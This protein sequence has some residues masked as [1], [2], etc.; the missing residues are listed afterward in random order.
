MNTANKPA[1]NKL[2]QFTA[3]KLLKM[4]K[5]YMA[6][7]DFQK[8][9]PIYSEIWDRSPNDKE[10]LVVLS[11]ILTKLAYREQAILLLESA[12]K[13]FG[14]REDVLQIL[15]DMAMNME[16]FDTA[17]KIFRIYIDTYPL[18]IHAYNNLASTLNSQERFDE[19]ID[20][21]QSLLEVYP[22]NA[23]LWNTLGAAVGTRDG[24]IAGLVFLE[25]ASR[26]D[27]KNPNI[28]NNIARTYLFLGRTEDTMEVGN[29]VLKL[30][31]N[32]YDTK[33]LLSTC[34]LGL[35]QLDKGWKYY[36][37]RRDARRIAALVYTNNIPEWSG[38]SLADKSIL[39]MSE[40]GLGDEILFSAFIT[41]IYNEAAQVYIGC[42]KRLISLFKRTFPKAIV[43]EHMTA[44]Q[45]G[46]IMRS[47]PDVEIARNKG[48]LTV[49]YRISIGSIA[50]FY[51]KSHDDI[52]THEGGFLV[53]DPT[54]VKYW[55]AKLDKISDKPKVG[56][57]WRSGNMA[58]TRKLGYTELT[59]WDTI[60]KTDKVNF[61]NIQYG[62]CQEEIAAA[63]KKFGV[64]IHQME[65]IDLKKDIDDSCALFKC[66]DLTLSPANAPGWQS[67]AVGTPVWWLTGQPYWFFGEQKPKMISNSNYI[68]RPIDM[69]IEVYMKMVG[70]AFNKFIKTGDADAPYYMYNKD[71]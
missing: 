62:E 46:H 47:Y 26:L 2:K 67:A 32:A 36:E 29:K 49:D 51:W 34:Y 60:L 9:L 59:D 30:N 38:Q 17:E 65:G 14:A 66:F 19:S 57:T 64:K 54:R 16:M 8:S 53:A 44:Q 13:T 68:E 63:E 31:P 69:P 42:D 40:Q 23:T 71:R 1:L 52:P 15:G 3:A 61:V 50:K 35:G 25:E 7:Q 70:D 41:H 11:F 39:I 10:I 21:L 24:E 18:A 22:E 4:G 55:Q 28:L 48:E 5:K 37:A 33:F 12:L 27:P 45:K 58:A 56:I 43:C 20:L 6:E